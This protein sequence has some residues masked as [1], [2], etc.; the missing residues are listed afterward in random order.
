MNKE[1]KDNE[2]TIDDFDSLL[3]VLKE[4]IY[5]PNK[6]EKDDFDYGY[7]GN[8][9]SIMVFRGHKEESY[10]LE[11]TLERYIKEVFPKLKL[12]KDTF[13]IISNEY[14]EGCKKELKG[15]IK[16]Q[17][18]LPNDNDVW[19]LGQHYG[20]KTPLLD[21]TRSF[22]IALYFAFEEPI[23]K[24]D[25]RVVYQL[26]SFL[27]IPDIIVE[28][29]FPIGSRIVAQR[30]VFTKKLS[31]ELESVNSLYEN[32]DF[33]E[34]IRKHRPL[35]KYRIKSSLRSDIMNY[36]ISLNI[37]C[38]TVYPDLQGAIKNC[39]LN[40]DNIL[41]LGKRIGFKE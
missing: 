36:L 30:G 28:P 34:E 15:K 16:E 37:D 19:A 2:I 31:D 25:Y 12:N 27:S 3:E 21:W 29:S 8:S 33:P 1:I 20:L 23:S 40:L 18:I 10:R 9:Y 11:S 6:R 5:E 17:Y 7:I 26:N 13:E 35:I 24:S 41:N 39:H 32:S 22:L 38:Y 4:F 14:L